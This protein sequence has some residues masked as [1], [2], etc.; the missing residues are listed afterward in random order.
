MVA[1]LF[2]IP[3]GSTVKHRRSIKIVC[4]C[5]TNCAGHFTLDAHASRPLLV[6]CCASDCTPSWVVIATEPATFVVSGPLLAQSLCNVGNV[7]PI[8]CDEEH[9]SDPG[10]LR[11]IR[12]TD[13]PR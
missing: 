3:I 5:D 7:Y 13:R 4:Q 9:G 11:R 6:Y 1:C 8:Y 10:L 12:Q 2:H